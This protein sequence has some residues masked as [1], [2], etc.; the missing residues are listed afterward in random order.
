M[1]LDLGATFVCHSADILL[2][3]RAFTDIQSRYAPLGFRFENRLAA[4]A[5]AMEKQS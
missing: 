1:L 4:E 3:Q 5:A 2:L